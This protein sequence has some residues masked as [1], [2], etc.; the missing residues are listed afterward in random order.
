MS[1]ECNSIEGFRTGMAH[2]LLAEIAER[3]DALAASGEPAAIDLL[4]LPMTPADRAELEELLGHGELEAALDVAG[5]SQI[6]ET[7]YAGVWWIRHFGGGEK[8]AAERIEI[9]ALP[10]ILM[11]HDADIAAASM[12]LRDD[13][14]ERETQAH[15]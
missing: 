3:L 13:L 10:D 4:S 2:S 11:T 1:A 6:W 12:R 7:G 15:V 8:V 14:A 9:T 5:L